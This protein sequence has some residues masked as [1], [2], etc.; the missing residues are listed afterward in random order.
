MEK[1]MKSVRIKRK[2]LFILRNVIKNRTKMEE[3]TM[4]KYDNQSNSNQCNSNQSNNS[5]SNSNQTNKNQT[6]QSNQSNQ[7]NRKDY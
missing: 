6:N 7:S 3:L 5:Q 4:S 2:G 1:I